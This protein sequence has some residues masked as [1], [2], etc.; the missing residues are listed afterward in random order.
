MAYVRKLIVGSLVVAL[1]VGAG[2]LLTPSDAWAKGKPPKGPRCTTCS[3]TIEIGG[4][5]CTLEDC[6]FDCVYTC[7]FPG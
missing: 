3:P 2:V 5:V 6:G 1:L 4:V 7:P